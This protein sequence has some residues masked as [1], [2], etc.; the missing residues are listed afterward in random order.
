[1]A[2]VTACPSGVQYDKLIEDTRA[3]VER[4]Y[5]A[6][7]PAS[8]APR[9]IFALFPHPGRLRALA[10]CCGRSA[11][12]AGSTSPRAARSA[13]RA[14]ARLAPAPPRRRCTVGCPRSRP[15]AGRARAARRLPAGLRPARV[16]RRR[17]P[18]DASRVLAAEGF[19]V[20]APR[21][22][23]CCGA[24][25]LHA[26]GTTRRRR[27]RRR[28]SRPSRAAT[29]VVVNAAGLRLGDE[30]LRPR[31][32]RRP[33]VGRARARRS[34]RRCRDVP[35]LLAEHEPRAARQ[36][37]EPDASPTTTPATSPT[38]RASARSRASCCARSPASS[39]VEPAELGA[40]L[41]LGGRLQPAE[42]RARRASSGARKARQPAA[43]PARRS[44]PP[45]T[46]AARCRSPRTRRLG[47]LPVL[48]P[49]ELLAAVDRGRTAMTRRRRRAP[50]PDG[51]DGDPAPTTRWRFVADAAR[52]LR[53]TPPR[54]AGGARG[55]PA[56]ARRG[57]HA[58]LPRRDARDPRGRLAGRAAAP[59]TS[60]NRRVEIT[61]PTD[62]KMVIN[63]LNSRRAGLH[64]RLRGLEL[65]DVDAT[66]SQGQVNLTDAIEGTIDIRRAPTA[67]ST[68]WTTRSR[69]CSC[70]R[71][72][73]T[74]PR[75]TSSSTATPVAGSLVDSGLL[76]V[77]QRP[78]AAR[79]GR[80]ARTSTCRR[81]S[82]HLE[83]RLWND[84][85]TLRPGR[86]RPR[87]AARSGRRC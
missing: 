74:C 29:H 58:R 76:P 72:A 49:M 16:L 59:P 75:S 82:R 1:M 20:H 41:R 71:A 42:P 35:E 84:V 32:A 26:G 56:S 17:Q 37:L 24:L 52:A 23:R 25:Q 44:W 79:Q 51:R 19:E 70:A 12:A 78:A 38:R 8:A 40:V 3:Q 50:R 4:R 55:A 57:R 46:P 83:A 47:P 33:R 27:S 5:D 9:A 69:R 21:A 22:P 34:P 14:C 7:A 54:A 13:G 2:C 66:W 67:A 39:C 73:G 60:Q 77:P 62:R 30:G 53:P 87:R 61:G 10:P 31:A 65:A 64:G 85:F 18:G 68:G 81:W 86:A 63:A 28:R 80:R 36:P 43:P 11:P 45:P 48:H 6:P 15:R